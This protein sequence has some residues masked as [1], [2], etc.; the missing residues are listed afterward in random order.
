MNGA[1]ARLYASVDRPS[2]ICGSSANRGECDVFMRTHHAHPRLAI[3][4]R[5]RTA[6]DCH[7]ELGNW[8][9]ITPGPPGE[10]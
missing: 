9:N 7:A 3:I 5:T 8:S 10:F 6:T 2:N 4:A 1:L